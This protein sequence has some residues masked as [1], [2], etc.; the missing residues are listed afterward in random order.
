[1][2][3]LDKRRRKSLHIMFLIGLV[4][5]SVIP[6][7]EWA[8][9]QDGSAPIWVVR[10]LSAS[11][12]GV[13]DP[14]GL[15]FSSA[16]NTFLLL[17][18]NA[19]VTLV[20]MDEDRVGSGVISELEDDAL[21]AAFDDRTGSL[22]VLKR[23]RSELVKIKSDGKGL[24]DASALPKRF[25]VNALGIA[26]PQGLAF[27]PSN[28]HLFILDAGNSQIVAVSAHPTLGFDVNEAMRANKVERISLKKLGAGLLRGIA[29]NPGNG[30]LYVAQSEQKKLY[31]LTQDGELVSTFD[32]AALE[33]DNP[34]AMTFAPSVDNT[35]D[36]NIYDLFILDTNTVSSQQ[37]EPSDSQ[38]VE[39]SLVAPAA[40]P[41]GTTLL[42]ASLVRIIDTSKAAWNPSSPDP[43][44]IDYWPA[45][46]RL[47]IA[48]SE[49]DEMPAYWVGKN[50]FQATTSG[51]L[52]NTC[53]TTS[54]TNEPTGVAINPNNNHI[55]FSTDSNDRIFEVSLGADG[56][57]CTADDTVTTTNVST[58]YG[59]TDAED[60]AYGNN[61][62][63]I[64]GGSAAEVYR[65]PLGP[66]G[67]LGG[68]DDGAMTH[69]DTA[70]L[71][72]A[73]LEAL[74]YN[75]NN[76]TL[77]IASP[78]PTN[79]YL[80]ETTTTGTLLRAYDLS[81]MG[82]AGNIRSDVTFAPG[83]QNP[84]VKN[85]Y[86]ASR[87]VDNDRN[88]LENDG[89]IWEISLGS[90]QVIVTPTQTPNTVPTVGTYDDTHAAWLYSGGWSVYTGSGPANNTFH[91]TSAIGASAEFRFTG[92]RFKLT[93]T[94]HPNRGLIDVYVD[95]AKI[96]TINAYSSSL[97]WQ[98]TYTSPTLTAGN[99]TVHF[100]HAGS[101]GTYIDLDAITILP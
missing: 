16:A 64:A 28:G 67:V 7:H 80:G 78:K 15:A 77:L 96:A 6:A 68:G 32:L 45:T 75:A 8:S 62:L 83:S 30:H 23:G 86:I 42:P 33:I 48:D 25:A 84:A 24:P 39:V 10:S 65:I 9:A 66:N 60:V 31:E 51:A 69:F 88:R 95:G 93:F 13:T 63:F 5:A 19:N 73:D 72:F 46:G 4:I 12:Y 17:D 99:H 49:V 21:N 1:M 89:K 74:G 76:G 29:Y 55:F 27:D 94:K 22:F 82:S 100:V 43:A 79:R 91:Y 44:G 37:S 53:S 50:V 97:L 18:G 54:F 61:T 26:D 11:E 56:Q 40:L 2:S 47:L 41:S 70:A 92:T 3:H 14:K 34:S 20:K 36:P 59:I 98:Q 52:V 57:Y 90:S 71:G 58:L 101:A 87:G 81:L 38:L 85:I 35:D